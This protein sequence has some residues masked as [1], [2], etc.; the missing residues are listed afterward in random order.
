[1]E[2]GRALR[3][4]VQNV[5]CVL[6]VAPGDLIED[7]VEGDLRVRAAILAAFDIVFR[8]LE[9]GVVDE[10]EI[11][12]LQVRHIKLL[13][14]LLFKCRVGVDQRPERRPGRDPEA[15]DVDDPVVVRGT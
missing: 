12:L 9:D 7:V 2:T 6:W 13:D 8:L 11:G 5:L 4:T 3:R 10:D 1:M 14:I 15:G